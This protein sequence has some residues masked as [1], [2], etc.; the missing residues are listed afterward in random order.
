M[1]FRR[2][3]KSSSIV[4]LCRCVQEGV[5]PWSYT[6]PRWPAVT[7]DPTLQQATGIP[8]SRSRREKPWEE[9]TPLASPSVH[10]RDAG[11]ALISVRRKGRRKGKR[12]ECHDGH[13]GTDTSRDATWGRSRGVGQEALGRPSPRTAGTLQ[14]P[15]GMGRRCRQEP[16]PD[17][18]SESSPCPGSSEVPSRPGAASPAFRCGASRATGRPFCSRWQPLPVSGCHLVSLGRRARQVV[19]PRIGSPSSQHLQ[20]PAGRHPKT[21]WVLGHPPLGDCTP[22]MLVCTP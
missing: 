17:P 12:S 1:R 3:K 18:A 8:R 16:R 15:A 14:V 6:H 10:G 13:T 21:A 22:P 4:S 19:T 9:N 20:G 11:E 7:G 2:G 5:Q